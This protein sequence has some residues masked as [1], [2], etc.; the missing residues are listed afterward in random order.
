MLGG[1]DVLD[2]VTAGQVY[3]GVAQWLGAEEDGDA[4]YQRLGGVG[5]AITELAEQVLLGPDD[6]DAAWLGMLGDDLG[7]FGE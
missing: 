7:E 6:V 3:L 4:G 5:L 2:R 1:D